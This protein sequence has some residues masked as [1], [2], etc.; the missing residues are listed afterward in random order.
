MTS[1][2]L[3]HQILFSKMLSCKQWC[4]L[5]LLTIGWTSNCLLK[6]FYNYN[7]VYNCLLKY[8]YNYT[9][10]YNC[11]FLK[12]HQLCSCLTTAPS[13]IFKTTN[14]LC[15]CLSTASWIIYKTTDQLRRCLIHAQGTTNQSEASSTVSSWQ[16]LSF[17]LLFVLTQVSPQCHQMVAKVLFSKFRSFAPFLPESTT[18]S[19][20][21]GRAPT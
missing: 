9:K 20:S 5:L 14:Q 18:S 12:L 10:V 16:D 2:L 17:G 19:W 15:K 4:S 11:L 3:L 21:R 8:F 1:H 13:I 7:R 6:Y